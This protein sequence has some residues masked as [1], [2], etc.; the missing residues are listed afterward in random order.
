[1]SHNWQIFTTLFQFPDCPQNVN[2]LQ[3]IFVDR[4]FVL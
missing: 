2:N 4:K 3:P 1:L